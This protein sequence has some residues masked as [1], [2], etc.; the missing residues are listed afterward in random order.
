MVKILDRYLL[1]EALRGWLAITLILWLILA[2]NRLVRYLA[3]AAAGELPADVVFVL[4]G[5]K[6]AWFLVYVMPFSLALGIVMALGRMYRDNEMTV[7]SACAVGPWR[8]YKPLLGM[9][10]VIALLLVWLALFVTPGIAAY[11]ARLEKLAQEEADVSLLGAGRFNEIS[12]G[13]LTFYSERL[14]D[15]KK[16]MHNLFV[17]VREDARRG[18]APQVMVAESASRMI[19]ETGDEYVVFVDGYRYEG[20][21]GDAEYRIMQFKRQG[22][23]IELPGKTELVAKRDAVPT[24]QL[25]TS[26]DRSD[27]VELQ[28][29]LSVPV[30]V[31][32]LVLLSVPLSRMS[33]RKGRFGGLA[34]AFLVFVV[35]YNLLGTAKVWVEQGAIP[36]SIGLWW[37]HL[38][39]AGL[40]FALLVNSNKLAYW[41]RR[42]A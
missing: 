17:Y 15:D 33:P 1:R 35:Y 36:T 29:R 12:G 6:T 41:L 21:P 14:S 8:I 42:R 22:V 27:I 30:S 32:V 19:N 10:V 2:S 34:M 3:Q 7:L 37:V 20:R 26:N 39:P 9:G 4:L 13:D 24:A 25:L 18:K 28:W 11:G 5:V 38:L 16:N 23:L 31:M 40:A